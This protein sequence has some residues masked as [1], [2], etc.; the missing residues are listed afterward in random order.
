M[1]MTPEEISALRAA[2]ARK[3]DP[4]DDGSWVI[5][6]VECKAT[7]G[8]AAPADAETTAPYC[9]QCAFGYLDKALEAFNTLDARIARADSALGAMTK[10]ADALAAQV[11]HLND[12]IAEQR[13]P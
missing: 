10:G 2:I 9:S 7:V 5:Q 12:R 1:S 13:K 4:R 11:R 3:I 8:L 6:C